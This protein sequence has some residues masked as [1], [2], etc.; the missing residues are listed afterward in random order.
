MNL[1]RGLVGETPIDD[2]SGL[3]PRHVRTVSQLNV[4]EN[5]NVGEAIHKYLS[6]RPTKRMAPFTRRWMLNVHHV[7]LGKV[8]SWAGKIRT[9]DG[10]NIGI[11]AS[12]VGP[13]L[14][15]L[16]QDI[17]YWAEH[18]G[19]VME[20][21]AYVHHKAASIHPFL[22]GN[23]RWARLLGQIWQYRLAGYYTEWPESGIWNGTSPVRPEYI[24]ALQ[25]ADRGNL[26]PLINLQA[27]YTNIKGR[28]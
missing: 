28:C 1:N 7:M 15:Q 2:V 19:D 16:A 22:N 10:L 23:G 3:I 5:A 13:A 27:R 18:G 14:E 9:T 20:Q 24:E 21:A 11:P 6:R 8:W 17:D 12:S 25:E 4:V 26:G